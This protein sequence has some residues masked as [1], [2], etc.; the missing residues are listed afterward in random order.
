[1]KFKIKDS[2]SAYNGLPKEIYLLFTA[3]IITSIGSFVLPLLTLILSQKLG[4]SETE[5]GNFS[6]LL[7]LSQGPCL[8]LGGK[9]IDA[10]GQKKMLV[11]CQTLGALFYFMCGFTK[12]HTTLLVFVMIAADL[13]VAASPAY[14]TMVAR[15]TVPDN[16]K[17]SYS[18]LYLGINIGMAVSP[19]I[20][21][22]LFEKHLPLL[23]VLDA[24]TTLLSTG[25]IALYIRLPKE[26]RREDT[27]PAAPAETGRDAFSIVVL[28]NTPVLLFFL[29][30]LFV[31]D[32]TYIQWS[33]MLPLQ[34]HELYGSNGARFYSF[35]SIVNP[36]ICTVFTPLLTKLT[37]KYHPLAVV[38]TGGIC[39]FASYALFAFAKNIPLFLIAGTLYTFGEILIVI[40]IGAFIAEH[41]P[42]AYLGRMNAVRLFLQGT[43]NA[44]GPLV[45]GR[46][47]PFSGYRFSWLLVA[48]V[49]LAGSVGMYFLN[50]EDSKVQALPNGDGG[51]VFTEQIQ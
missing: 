10:I 2:F 4:M 8:L 6:A 1:M 20:G 37:A 22:L 40:N 41:S 11:F 46:V 35:I 23:F 45:M 12:D 49:A 24:G 13:F 48:A 50:K 28:K 47:L 29:L 17:A 31:F 30:F 3:R 43:A 39:Y 36:V 51:D 27:D 42:G 32:F 25:L 19:L 33:F 7:I 9:L 26:N 44:L 15:L 5:T 18:L 38:T 14:Q 21:G 34:F 16:R